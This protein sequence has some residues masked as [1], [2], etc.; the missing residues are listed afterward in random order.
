MGEGLLLII[1]GPSG[2]GKGTIINALRPLED[3]ALSISVTTRNIR[4]GESDGTHYF[5]RTKDEFIEMRETGEL[6]EHASYNGNYYGTPKFYVDRKIKEGKAV[7]LEI[8]IQGALQVKE[9]FA[10]SLLVFIAP[11]T[12]DELR[13]RL[14]GRG[15]ENEDSLNY[16]LNRAVQEFKAIEH[17]DYLVINDEIDNAVAKIEHII[18]AEMLRPRKNK[19]TIETFWEEND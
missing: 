15:T 18:R 7:I 13:R 14:I 19:K 17:Y 12:R 11:P 6:L 8:D 3:F 9:K 4:E 16:R 10:E 5:F 1:S 2:S